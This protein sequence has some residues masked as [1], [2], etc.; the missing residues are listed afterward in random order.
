MN[1]YDIK[2]R[3]IKTT[4]GITAGDSSNLKTSLIT[5]GIK[6]RSKKFA[7]SWKTMKEELG[8]LLKR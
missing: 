7:K 4:N 2:Y 6:R 3:Y 5:T 8:K 1:D